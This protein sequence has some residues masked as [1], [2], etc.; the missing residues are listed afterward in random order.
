MTF[1]KEVFQLISLSG[2]RSWDK[3]PDFVRKGAQRPAA[4]WIVCLNYFF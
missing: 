1:S 3:N 2:V 4:G